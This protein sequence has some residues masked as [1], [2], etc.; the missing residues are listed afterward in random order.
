MYIDVLSYHFLEVKNSAKQGKIKN[1]IKRFFWWVCQQT[2]KI[3][4][5][6]T[7]PPDKIG[8]RRGKRGLEGK[9]ELG[10]VKG[11]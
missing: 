2:I 5:I 3:W 11:K 6:W 10:E 4:G 7:P 9:D 8:I 1:R